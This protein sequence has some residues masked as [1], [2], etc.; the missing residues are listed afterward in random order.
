MSLRGALGDGS[1]PARGGWLR[2]TKSLRFRLNAERKPKASLRYWTQVDSDGFAQ[3][4]STSVPI[5]VT[6]RKPNGDFILE[7]AL[8]V[9]GER[10]LRLSTSW[11]GKGICGGNEFLLRPLPRWRRD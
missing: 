11:K 8:D 2:G 4:D 6:E 5:E 10:Y 9:T 1:S 3:G 7:A